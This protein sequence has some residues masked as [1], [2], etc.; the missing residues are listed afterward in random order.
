MTSKK[1]NS[2][3]AYNDVR[4]IMDLA[5]RQPGLT[6]ECA[7]NGRAIYF[8]QRCNKFRNM[9]REIQAEL[10][11]NTPGVRA[12]TAYDALVI[13]LISAA[14]GEPDRKGTMVLFEH[15]RADGVLRDAD[16]NI[17]ELPKMSFNLGED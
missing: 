2:P 15:E 16:G 9:V 17:I 3:A 6:F 13:R 14:T 5:V 1:A 4:F 8:L 12:Q 10:L 7:T 11:A